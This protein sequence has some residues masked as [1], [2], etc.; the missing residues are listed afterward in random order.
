MYVPGGVVVSGVV[1][2]EPVWQFGK[3]RL[4]PGAAEESVLFYTEKPERKKW[5]LWL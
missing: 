5:L 1:F 3:K 4:H 2:F